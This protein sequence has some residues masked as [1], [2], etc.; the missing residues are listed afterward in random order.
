MDNTVNL[1]DVG[2]LSGKSSASARKTALI[3]FNMFLEYIFTKD[4]CNYPHKSFS[5]SI[6]PG[7]FTKDVIG[8]FADYLV[9]VKKIGK[10]G[11]ALGYISQVRIH[12]ESSYEGTI[13]PFLV[14]DSYYTKLRQNVLKHYMERC[15]KNGEKLVDSAPP[16]TKEDL[17]IIC[18]RLLSR[19]S[20][21]ANEDR[22]LICHQFQLIGRVSEPGKAKK[23]DYNYVHNDD[24]TPL[25]VT[26]NRSKNS[27]TQELALVCHYNSFAECPFHCLGTLIAVNGDSSDNLYPLMLGAKSTSNYINRVLSDCFDNWKNENEFDDDEDDN[28]DN[29]NNN[30]NNKNN[31]NKNN[32]NK[33]IR[34]EN[35]NKNKNNSISNSSNGI[36]SNS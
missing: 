32:N 22:C 9:K 1:V 24:R 12:L 14:G 5:M 16:M 3:N 19:N 7:F 20:P 23:S 36:G 33:K 2:D 6:P 26:L 31:N 8:K 10:C 34:N 13:L 15:S 35:K 27:T 25:M 11:T 29:D 18:M 17:K 30:N 21:T 28:N 4:S